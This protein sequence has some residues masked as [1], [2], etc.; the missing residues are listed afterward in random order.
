MN[1]Y[2]LASIGISVALLACSKKSSDARGGAASVT[3]ASPSPV[4]PVATAGALALG[5]VDGVILPAEGAAPS[6][7]VGAHV[8]AENH[9]EIDAI[10]DADGK[11]S[12]AGIVP[13]EI[14]LYVT[15][16][17]GA[18]LSGPSA[19]QFGLKIPG[20]V[21]EAGKAN[22]LG[23]QTLKRTGSIAGKVTFYSNPNGLDLT[24][25]DVFVP[26]TGFIAKTDATGAF[27][28]SGL[29]P[30]SY[31]LRA[32]HTGFAVLDRDG[33]TIDEAATTSLG[34]LV[35]SLSTGPEGRIE[36][37]A[38]Q[39]PSIA[40]TVTKV[41]TSRTVALKLTYDQDAALMKISDEP[42]FIQKEWTT[43]ATTANWTFASDGRKR[44]YVMYSDLN[45]LESSPFYDDIV[46]DTVAPTLT[47]LEMMHGFAQ[48]AVSHV[49]I[50]VNAS[51][52][53]TGVAS[54][55]FDGD[56]TA[57]TKAAAQAFGSGAL[58][59]D[60]TAGNGPRHVTATVTDYVGN[61]STVAF[62][63]INV[64]DS[65]QSGG[66]TLV[67]FK[68]YSDLMTFKK[69]EG[70]F[71]IQ[72][73]AVFA[74]G[75]TVEAGTEIW[76]SP[77]ATPTVKGKFLADGTGDP[78][79][80]KRSTPDTSC[81]SPL[82]PYLI[83]NGADPGVT[84]ADIIRN[85]V[86]EQVGVQADGGL[87]EDSTFDSSA[88]PDHLTLGKIYKTGLD[89]LTV[90]HN[91]FRQW[92]T[93]LENDAGNAN[94]RVIDNTDASNTVGTALRQMSAAK[95][96]VFTGNV[97]H[98]IRTEM[99]RGMV[100]PYNSQAVDFSGT[101]LSTEGVAVHLTAQV[102]ASIAIAGL[103]F[104]ACASVA[105]VDNNAG[106]N[107]DLT[108]SHS[109][110]ACDYGLAVTGFSSMGHGWESTTNVTLDHVN[111]TVSDAL[112]FQDTTTKP[113]SIVISNSNVACTPATGFCDLF[114]L[115][116]D[117]SNPALPF[118]LSGNNINCS[119]NASQGCR[120]FTVEGNNLI[121]VGMQPTLNGNY[122]TPKT[123]P[124]NPSLI[125]NGTVGSSNVE[126]HLIG[127]A[128]SVALPTGV[129]SVAL[130]AGAGP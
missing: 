5:T 55:A 119:G 97:F 65:G 37:V 108:I 101:T 58:S 121:A 30:G 40:G 26:G 129:T 48:S 76:I 42:S 106:A 59:I 91:H 105:T 118:T 86:F 71:V 45:G 78:I 95:N 22:D 50:T 4:T 126:F 72:L 87:I 38:N 24:G 89:T 18:T 116:I 67:T 68:T 127:N 34:D 120:G 56:V 102:P 100:E 70:P 122:W 77:S 41:A 111:L 47:S 82:A 23:T 49:P 80:I 54:V 107:P 93:V 115:D 125:T 15:S 7:V 84:N 117:Q 109:V 31:R 62:D 12:V 6:T 104:T 2:V 16:N 27:V 81:S 29:P 13:G 60:L 88:C 85:V 75:L 46:V 57:G 103:T 112:V 53:G 83:L 114:N 19:S 123:M 113:A 92:D 52:T 98:G 64:L 32:Q 25:S 90:R 14:A 10:T 63:D 66:G 124:A 79:H 74:G 36:I 8:T 28:L 73:S 33:V 99:F 11:F 128:S 94:T 43:V 61:V 20:V 96:T 9:P 17:D 21:V 35:L 110:F 51:D 1:R 39:T 130:I 44:I 3:A 69:A